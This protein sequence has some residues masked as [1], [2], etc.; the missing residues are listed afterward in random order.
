MKQAFV[1]ARKKICERGK[2]L[3]I[4]FQAEVAKLRQA[5]D[6]DTERHAAQDPK[7]QLPAYFKAKFHA[8][9]EGNLSWEAALE[10]PMAHFAVSCAFHKASEHACI[11][12]SAVYNKVTDRVAA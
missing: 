4:D 1:Q 8:Y 10:V 7:V 5:A 11:G 2:Q 12:P 6:W 3:G 9:S